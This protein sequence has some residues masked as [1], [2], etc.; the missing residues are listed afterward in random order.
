[1]KC[2]ESWDN[3]LWGRYDQSDTYWE[4]LKDFSSVRGLNELKLCSEIV[5]A[6]VVLVSKLFIWIEGNI[7]QVVITRKTQAYSVIVDLWTKLVV[8]HHKIY[9]TLYCCQPLIF[10][11]IWLHL[12]S[13]WN[14]QTQYVGV[15][16]VWKWPYSMPVESG[17]QSALN[18]HTVRSF[19]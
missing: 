19:T 15:T 3:G 9:P 14:I 4:F 1:M 2:Y 5:N 17:L 8:K 6:V 11:E 16:V 13:M 7:L 10:K 18:R 12:K